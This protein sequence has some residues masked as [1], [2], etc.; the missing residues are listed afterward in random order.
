MWRV[1]LI[2]FLSIDAKIEVTLN[3]CGLVVAFYTYILVD[4]KLKVA[5]RKEKKIEGGI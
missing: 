4:W 3:S 1:F 5:F 2:N